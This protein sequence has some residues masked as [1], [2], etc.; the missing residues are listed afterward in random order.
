MKAEVLIMSGLMLIISGTVWLVMETK[1]NKKPG[2]TSNF[3]SITKAYLK[4]KNNL[5]IKAI[6]SIFGLVALILA[7]MFWYRSG[8]LNNYLFTA[9]SLFTLVWYQRVNSSWVLTSWMGLF[10]VILGFF[11]INLGL[12]WLLT[13]IGSGYYKQDQKREMHNLAVQMSVLLNPV[14]S[15]AIHL[16]PLSKNVSLENFPE[17]NAVEAK[18]EGL[19]TCPVCQETMKF[20]KAKDGEEDIVYDRCPKCQ[21]VFF[22]DRDYLWPIVKSQKIKSKNKLGKYLCPRC[23]IRLKRSHYRLDPENITIY[24]CSGCQGN[25]I[26]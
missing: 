15:V 8:L 1:N 6:S 16:N 19:I 18:L 4:L 13:V 20:F 14:S 12:I 3:L 24:T 5:Y 23:Q 11:N 7:G 22:D 9:L 26:I 17:I 21:A 10:T 2:N 25:L